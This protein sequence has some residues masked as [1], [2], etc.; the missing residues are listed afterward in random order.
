[1]DVAYQACAIGAKSEGSLSEYGT[2][3]A[4]WVSAIEILA[5]PDKRH[6]DLESVLRLLDRDAVDKRD[7]QRRYRLKLKNPKTKKLE[8]RRVSALQRAYIYLYRA[9]NKF[10]HGNPVSTS[11]LLTLNRGE[12][13]GLP[14]LATVVYR[15]ALVAYLDD[16]YPK[17][18]N[19]IKEL[20][21]RI[22]ES[23][24]D[25]TYGEALAEMFGYQ[26]NRISRR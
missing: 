21:D 16:R 12:R 25:L 19:T 26:Q 22:G 17:R 23:F 6:A 8:T 20:R 10:L 24:E 14:R 11:T 2:Q 3:V 9:R 5:W 1:L 13:V 4:L 15:A 7:R 18:I